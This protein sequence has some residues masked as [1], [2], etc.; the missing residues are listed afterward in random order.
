MEYLRVGAT[1]WHVPCRASQFARRSGKGQ[2]IQQI[3]ASSRLFDFEE[4]KGKAVITSEIPCRE[5]AADAQVS[6]QRT[7]S[8]EELGP[9]HRQH[10]TFRRRRS[11]VGSANYLN[12][13]AVNDDVVPG[14]RG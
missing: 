2:R 7:L 10:R 13:I 14:L 8:G 6:S 9:A 12:K 3:M 11:T 5:P 1:H 4:R